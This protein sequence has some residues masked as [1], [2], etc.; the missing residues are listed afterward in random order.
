MNFDP[1]QKQ[2]GT[3]LSTTHPHAQFMNNTHANYLQM[4][5]LHV[6]KFQILTSCDLR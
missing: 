2:Q 6:T 1:N 4:S 3:P 5:L